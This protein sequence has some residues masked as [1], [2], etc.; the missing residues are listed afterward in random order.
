MPQAIRYTILA[1]ALAALP[2]LTAAQAYSGEKAQQPSATDTPSQT[3]PS[4]SRSEGTMG[5]GASSSTSAAYQ[6]ALAACDRKPANQQQ[7]CRDAADARYN[8][9]GGDKSSAGSNPMSAPASK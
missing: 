6:K 2:G 3:S 9:A 7:A 8:N 4:T 5:K 1:L